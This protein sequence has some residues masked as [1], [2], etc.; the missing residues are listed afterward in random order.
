MPCLES[1][2][3]S[4]VQKMNCRD[5]KGQGKQAPDVLDNSR[6]VHTVPTKNSHVDT[7]GKES[8]VTKAKVKTPRVA[9]RI[10]FTPNT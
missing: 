5:N 2:T 9:T 10:I 6:T 1:G 8:E 3:H 7:A 4:L